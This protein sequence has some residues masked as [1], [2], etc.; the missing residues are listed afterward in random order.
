VILIANKKVIKKRYTKKSV[1]SGGVLEEYFGS[2]QRSLQSQFSLCIFFT[3]TCYG[4]A[5]VLDTVHSFMHAVVCQR[6]Y[7]A[8]AFVKRATALP[9]DLN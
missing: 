8:S 1:A 2:H 5:L 4:G 9:K 6:L 7:A 3:C